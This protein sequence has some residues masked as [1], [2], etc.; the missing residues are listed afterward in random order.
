MRRICRILLAAEESH[1]VRKV[2]MIH[3]SWVIARL[4]IDMINHTC[5]GSNCKNDDVMLA[6]RRGIKMPKQISQWCAR[7]LRIIIEF[8]S[9]QM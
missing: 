4:E 6:I 9:C 3:V 2:K 7:R 5:D 1:D 8:E